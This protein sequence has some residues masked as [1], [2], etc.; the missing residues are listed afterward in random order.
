MRIMTAVQ[1]LPVSLEDA[2]EFFSSPLNLN[3]ITPENMS[4]EMR[5]VPEGPMYEGMVL[6]YRISPFSGI[7]MNWLTEI[8]HVLDR[9][10]FI[11]EQ[12][13]GPYHIWHHEHHFRQTNQGVE[14]TDHLVYDIGWGVLG[15][16]MGKLLVDRRVDEIFSYRRQKLEEI[17]GPN[18]PR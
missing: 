16:F 11:D 13:L 10:Y 17:F 15:D 2:W 1:H 3:L 8:T 14:M 4:F 18:S 5:H 9:Q 12:R 6:A 7:K